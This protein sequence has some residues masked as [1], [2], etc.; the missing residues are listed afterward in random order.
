MSCNDH[1]KSTKNGFYVCNLFW[2]NGWK[3][4][5]PKWGSILRVK[6]NS[7]DENQ[8]ILV[9]FGR[10]EKLIDDDYVNDFFS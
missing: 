9:W 5:L 2:K 7:N 8:S 1:T 10:I 4:N 3:E 6:T